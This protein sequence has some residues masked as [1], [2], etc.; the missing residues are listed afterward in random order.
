MNTSHIPKHFLVVEDN[1]MLSR[2]LKNYIE[3]QGHG[4]TCLLDSTTA[5]DWLERNACD[6]VLTDMRMPELDGVALTKLI[7]EKHPALPILISTSLGYDEQLMQAALNAGAN[8]YISKVMGPKAL[9]IA[10]L[11]TAATGTSPGNQIA[12]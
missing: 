2:C 11:Q 12:A 9:L 8:G 10:L 1:P 5:I 4:C 3:E 6:A 7:R